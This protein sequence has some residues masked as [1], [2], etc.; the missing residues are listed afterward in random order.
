MTEP[1]FCVTCKHHGLSG[2]QHECFNPALTEV[3]MVT[4]VHQ[5]VLCVRQRQTQTCQQVV[6]GLRMGEVRCGSEGKFW[7]AKHERQPEP[8]ARPP[9]QQE[10]FAQQY[11]RDQGWKGE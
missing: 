7:E 1:R 9:G 11:W 10:S 3:D 8:R 2:H 4:G 6:Y 5:P